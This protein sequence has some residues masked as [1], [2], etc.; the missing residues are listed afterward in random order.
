[1][2]KAGNLTRK[3]GDNLA[4]DNLSFEIGPKEIVGLLGHNGAGKTTIMKMITGF[5]EPT[6]GSITVDD[7]DAWLER[8]SIQKKIGYLP[9]NCPLYPEMS[10]MDY[11]EYAAALRGVPDDQKMRRIAYAVEKT[12]LINVGQK[13]VSTLSR[14]YKQRLGVAQAILNSPSILILDEPTNGL[15]P[16]Q[17]LEMRALI[18]ELSQTATV[19]VS[20][21][22]LQEVQAVCDRVIIIAN[23]KLALD[24][25]IAKLQR[26]ERIQVIVDASPSS[27]SE[28][29]SNGNGMTILSHSENNGRY[30]YLLEAKETDASE[31]VPALAKKLTEKGINIYAIQPLSRDLETIFGEISAGMTDSETQSGPSDSVLQPDSELDTGSGSQST[32]GEKA[33]D[34]GPSDSDNAE[35]KPSGG[36][37][38]N[39]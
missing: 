35:A 23:G 29:L 32:A 34:S 37:D 9:E 26:A 18:K 39:Q 38:A 30:T 20:T 27:C 16:S 4:V 25:E 19:I 15:D 10:V 13:V 3:Y 8:L 6:S 12:R 22:I 2:I 24:A 21:H 1:M 36:N 14:G 5:L 28:I 31:K 11:L 17:I 7:A 33:S